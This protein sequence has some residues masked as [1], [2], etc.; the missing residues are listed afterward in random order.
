MTALST[1]EPADTA[2]AGRIPWHDTRREQAFAAWLDRIAASHGL[3][4]GTVRLASA[5]ASFRRYFRVDAHGAAATR[6][7]M[8]APPDKENSAPF[9]QVAALM[10]QAG[11]CAPQVLA[12]DP[13]EGFLLLDDLGHQTML[14]MIDP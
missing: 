4:A 13:A 10:A 8:D 12:W 3:V 11:V 9:V 6:I 7:I 5:D 2:P 14:D 1:T